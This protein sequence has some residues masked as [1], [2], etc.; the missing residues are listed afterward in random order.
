MDK[1]SKRIY[2]A[3]PIRPVSEAGTKE[4]DEEL[5]ENIDNVKEYC[6]MVTAAGNTPLSSILLCKEFLNEDDPEDRDKGMQIGLDLVSVSDEVWVFS[7]RITEGMAAEIRLATELGIPVRIIKIIDEHDIDVF[8]SLLDEFENAEKD[9]ETDEI[10]ADTDP[11]SDE[12]DED[13]DDDSE[14][15]FAE[16][17]LKALF[18]EG[19]D[20]GTKN[21]GK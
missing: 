3:S 7:N 2:I 16:K 13:D 19:S 9:K 20:H 18:N 5:K 21:G 11:V 14:F 15:D 12:D 6:K 4:Y 10:E 1:K 8:F 17:L